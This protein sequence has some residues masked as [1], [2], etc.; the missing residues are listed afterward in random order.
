MAPHTAALAI[1]QAG[2]PWN[3]TLELPLPVT[4]LSLTKP[5]APQSMSSAAIARVA[6]SSPARRGLACLGLVPDSRGSE[7]IT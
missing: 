6:M 2:A 3:P 7:G 1:S 4:N 5:L